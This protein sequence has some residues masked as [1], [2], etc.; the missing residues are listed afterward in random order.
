MGELKKKK[1]EKRR[2]SKTSLHSDW[3]SL[4][5]SYSDWGIAPSEVKMLIKLKQEGEIE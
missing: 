4:L 2:L 1:I 5:P 3:G